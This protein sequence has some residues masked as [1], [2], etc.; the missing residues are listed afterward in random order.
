LRAEQD[1]ALRGTYRTGPLSYR[2]DDDTVTLDG[3][4]IW[5]S[6]QERRLLR[7][8]AVR[9]GYVC[10][11]ERLMTA[12]WGET[13]AALTAHRPSSSTGRKALTMTYHR[14]RQRLAPHDGLLERVK[15]RGMRLRLVAPTGESQS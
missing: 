5:L 8:L 2:F 3:V 9:V 11:Y 4:E 15:L 6:D 7:E 12:L 10:S 14:L 13:T 1:A